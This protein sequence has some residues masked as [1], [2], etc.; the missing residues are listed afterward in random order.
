MADGAARIRRLVALTL[1]T[2]T[3]PLWA[4]ASAPRTSAPA[5]AGTPSP[6][7]V[8]AIVAGRPLGYPVGGIDLSSHDHEH[9]PV[10]WT[11]EV[12][13]GSRFVYIK[14]TEGTGYVN[15]HFDADYD[16]ARAAGRYV[17]A[18]VFARPDLGDPVG[19]AESFLR[20][21]RFSHD[22]RTLVP[23]VDVE[24]PYHAI[25]TNACY[26]LDPTHL[27]AWL[28]AFLDRLEA[29]IG[30]PP[31]V[32]TDAY[33]WDPCFGTDPT[34]G[35]Y[36]LDVSDY[37]R[38]PP[39]LPAGWTAFAMWQYLPGDPHRPGDYDRDVVHGGLAGLAALA[40]PPRR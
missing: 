7:M 17:G 38:T 3:A 15:P 8:A 19:Q 11:T 30:R 18:Y 36:P 25:R 1:A 34:I 21:A 20:H 29:G 13:A 28:H 32:Y 5:P 10:G 22:A 14:A 40:W 27:R 33:W 24:R 35:R 39:K 23:F 6:G 37:S 26:D 12:A 2:L 4:T 16:A 31:M 9:F